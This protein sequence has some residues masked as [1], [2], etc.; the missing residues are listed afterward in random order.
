MED[1]KSGKNFKQVLVFIFGS[2]AISYKPPE[3]IKVIWTF[4]VKAAKGLWRGFNTFRKKYKALFI[5]ILV[6]IILAPVGYYSF[7]YYKSRL[8]Q[9]VQVRFRGNDPTSVR[10]GSDSAFE[11]LILDF[12]DS[13]V[14]LELVGKTVSDGISMIPEKN[15]EWKWENDRRLVFTPADDWSVGQKYALE[16]DKSLFPS[17]IKLVEYEYEFMTSPFTMSVNSIEFYID[18]LNP[19]LKQ[20]VS[21]IRFSHSVDPGTFENRIS[22]KTLSSEPDEKW[23]KD[24]EFK[25]SVAYNDYFSEAYITSE[26]LSVPENAVT[27][28][29]AVDKGTTSSNGGKPYNQILSRTLTIEG[30]AEFVKILSINAQNI[31]NDAYEMEQIFIIETKGKANAEEL[32]KYITVYELP[33]NKPAVEGSEEIRNFQWTDPMMVGQQELAKSRK[34]SFAPLVS[35]ENYSNISSFRF[36]AEPGHFIFIRIAR[37]APFFG[38]Y[39]LAKNIVGTEKLKEFPKELTILHDGALLSMSG[40]KKLSLL[41]R[42]VSEVKFSIGRVLPDQINHLVSQTNGDITNLRFRSWNFNQ[43]NLAENQYSTIRLNNSSPTEAEYF[44]FDFSSMLGSGGNGRLQNGLFFFN[45]NDYDSVNR[46]TGRL[47]D[48]RLVMITDLGILVK[49]NTD[50]TRDLF[51]QSIATGLPVAGAKVQIVGK[52]GIDLTVLNTDTNGHVKIPFF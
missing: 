16:L 34:I 2:L 30:K 10:P 14:K 38:G 37:G 18:P 52:N 4:M 13:A 47:R 50:N 51:V 41:A 8:P 7:Q 21:T 26:D 3:F 39:E 9:P 49:S 32:Q 6:L 22:L 15:G 28:Q 25:F 29:L 43:E 27:L 11:Q 46:K 36:N 45:V 24:R 33:V 20:V 44:S 5:S 17:H 48:S 40:E 23:Y 1:K 12:N 31:R 35:E 19:D 42:G